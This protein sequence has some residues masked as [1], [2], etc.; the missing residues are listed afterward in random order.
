MSSRGAQLH[1]RDGSP[2]GTGCRGRWFGSQIDVDYR[3]RGG[4]GTNNG[5]RAAYAS[6]PG[7]CDIVRS[8]SLRAGDVAQEVGH[9]DRRDDGH[10]RRQPP[11]GDRAGQPDAPP[12][13]GVAEVVGVPR[14]APEP[15]VEH[16]RSL[17]ARPGAVRRELPVAHDLEEHA[18]RPHHDPEPA[19][20]RPLDVGDGRRLERQRHQPHG[21][22]LDHEHL[23]DRDRE[24]AAAED[25]GVARVLTLPARPAQDVRREPNP[26]DR[27]QGEHQ[28][29]LPGRREERAH[30]RD[31]DQR[32]PPGHVDDV[33]PAEPARHQG[34][35][36]HRG[37][38]DGER[39][40]GDDQQVGHHART[41]DRS[42][43]APGRTQST[44]STPIRP[45]R[46]AQHP[47][48]QVEPPHAVTSSPTR[49]T[50][51]GRL[52]SNVSSH[53]CTVLT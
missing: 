22:A 39:G 32:Q 48:D 50:N 35:D 1:L 42:C 11:G 44:W 52:D 2:H 37:D 27:H 13:A 28:P 5:T 16:R 21:G 4:R 8:S 18:D 10:Q 46:K 7:R 6:Q 9:R 34:G 24:A 53:P 36:R 20:P 26:P 45:S 41:G 30:Q 15:G 33:D 23:A 40:P 51:A 47:T 43:G 19:R 31:G 12:D 25:R 3:R 17:V 14:P 29:R 49:S 38:R